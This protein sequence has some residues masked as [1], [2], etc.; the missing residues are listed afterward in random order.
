MEADFSHRDEPSARP[1]REP[2]DQ[3]DE[4]RR[5]IGEQEPKRQRKAHNF[6]RRRR[7]P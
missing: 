6:P 1:Q 5:L 4:L 7:T 3:I 2:L